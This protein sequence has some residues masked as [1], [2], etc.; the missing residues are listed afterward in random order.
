MV[1][2]MISKG[3]GETVEVKVKD[4]M[5]AFN[6]KQWQFDRL[7]TFAE[8]KGFFKFREYKYYFEKEEKIKKK[9]S[10]I[11][12]ANRLE[13]KNRLRRNSFTTHYFSGDIRYTIAELAEKTGMKKETLRVYLLNIESIIINSVKIHTKRMGVLNYSATD[14]TDGTIKEFKK[15]DLMCKFL[16]ITP[17]YA[18][19]KIC[20]KELVKNIY[21]LSKELGEIK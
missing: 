7:K 11:D 6:F 17:T 20:N 21:L 10:N 12:V 9:S 15:M 3:F 16:K 2:T 8:K 19:N 13:Y 1:E 14:T 5:Y 18:Y 4:F